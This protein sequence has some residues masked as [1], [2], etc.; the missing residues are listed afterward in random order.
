MGPVLSGLLLGQLLL[1]FLNLQTQ[2]S[3]SFDDHLLLELVNHFF[4]LFIS[5]EI[6]M[7]LAYLLRSL[8]QIFQPLIFG[9]RNF[10]LFVVKY[11][12]NS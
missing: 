1:L 7:S 3:I 10:Q 12:I 4:G 11:Y 2:D 5:F 9:D 8:L 6:A